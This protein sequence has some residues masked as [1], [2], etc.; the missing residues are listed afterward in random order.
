M[1][2][3]FLMCHLP[4]DSEHVGC[5][6]PLE[7]VGGLVGLHLHLEAGAAARH[8]VAGPC[9]S[10]H[11]SKSVLGHGLCRTKV[12]WVDLEVQVGIILTKWSIFGL[13]AFY[14]FLIITK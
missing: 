3:C 2:V 13:Q 8:T 6:L 10:P 5:F 4:S 9:A 7:M 14:L 12:R 1:S 11:V